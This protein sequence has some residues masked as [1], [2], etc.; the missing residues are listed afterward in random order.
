MLSNGNHKSSCEFTADIVS[1]LYNEIGATER[2]RFESHLAGCSTC[3]DEFAGISNARFSVFEWQKESFAQ[4][5]TPEIVIPYRTKRSDV[6]MQSTV[7][8]F[9][10]IR[11]LLA[12]SNWY[13]AA[14]MAGGLAVCLGFGFAAMTYFGRSDRQIAHSDPI[15]VSGEPVAPDV[16]PPTP[17]TPVDE[18]KNPVVAVN[19]AKKDSPVRYAHAAT[20]PQENRQAKFK[21]PA[22]VRQPR[23]ANDVAD[24]NVVPQNRKAPVLS[25]DSDDD[26]KSLRLTDLFDTVDARLGG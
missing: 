23:L 25:G 9:A 5:T 24:R 18:V 2:I 12:L 21:G 17:P 14:A 15:N 1:Y 11:N 4:L 8:F 19:A 10:G 3:T 16:A 6:E 13:S 7:G 20:S 26:D 22:I